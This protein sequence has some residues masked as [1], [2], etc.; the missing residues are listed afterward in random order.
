MS[1]AL[2]AYGPSSQTLTFLDPDDGGGSSLLHGATQD[3]QYDFDHDF[4]LPSQ[5]QHSQADLV[6]TQ[7]SQAS[8][9]CFL[10]SACTER[11]TT[12]VS[13]WVMCDKSSI[14]CFGSVIKCDEFIGG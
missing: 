12:F 10:F 3:S 6:V 5:T 8:P 2:D 4:T 13:K 9:H 1:E 11:V 14:L 7:K